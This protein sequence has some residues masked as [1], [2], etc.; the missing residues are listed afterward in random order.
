[1][2]ALVTHPHGLA[3][4]R[5]YEPLFTESFYLSKAM[6]LVRRLVWYW[7]LEWLHER[8]GDLGALGR[9]GYGE[10]TKSE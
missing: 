1:M 7:L 10:E 9:T 2:S 6:W 3:P 5:V 4:L 8:A